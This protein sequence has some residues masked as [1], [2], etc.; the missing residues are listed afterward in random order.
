MKYLILA[1]I[2]VIFIST[3]AFAK[4]G[5]KPVFI[6]GAEKGWEGWR[7]ESCW[8]L[9]DRERGGNKY[10]RFPHFESTEEGMGSLRSPE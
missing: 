8:S 3:Q 2:C 6:G 5:K 1:A 7:Y 10:A 4:S 9:T